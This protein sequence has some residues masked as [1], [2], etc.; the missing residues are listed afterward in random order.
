MA[1]SKYSCCSPDRTHTV[2]LGLSCNFRCSRRRHP[3]AGDSDTRL[4]QHCCAPHSSLQLRTAPPA[5][6]LRSALL[7]SA[8]VRPL[9]AVLPKIGR[10]AALG[11]GWRQGEDSVC[12]PHEPCSDDTALYRVLA[13]N[14]KYEPH[15]D[16]TALHMAQV[17]NN[18]YE[19]H[20]D[21]TSLHMVHSISNRFFRAFLT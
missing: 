6:V 9:S 1:I 11:P 5:V 20:S 18:K 3:P 14:Y 8:P 13:S 19:P 16:N 21:N 7:P 4:P 15:S 17:L 10:A 12:A 2:A